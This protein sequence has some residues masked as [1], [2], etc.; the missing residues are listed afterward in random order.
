MAD[1]ASLG[2]GLYLNDGNFK[3]RLMGAYRTAGTQSRRFSGTIQKD[4]K[5]IEAAYKRVGGS[6]KSVAGQ[7]AGITGL[8]LSLG[9]IINASRK[10]G[11]A[12]SDLSAITGITGAQLKKL[13]QTAQEMGRSTGYGA[14]QAAEALKLM[15]SAKPELIQLGDSLSIATQSALTLAQAGGTTLPDATRA[16]ALSLNQFGAGAKEADRYI[17][18]LAAGAKY[19]ASEIADTTEAIKKSGVTAAQAGIGFEQL[20][21]AIQVLAAREVK[22]AEAGTALRNVI[23]LLERSTEKG[24]KPSVVGLSAALENLSKKNYST[25]QAV[26]LFGLENINAATILLES[27]NN[28]DKLTASLTGTQTAHEQASIR[29]NTLNGDLQRLSSTFDGLILKVGD[30]STGTLRTGI[31]SLTD[32]LGFLANNFDTVA[33]IAM[34][35]LLPVLAGKMTKGLQ[36]STAEWWKQRNAVIESA[37]AQK[38]IAQKTLETTAVQLKQNNLAFGHYMQMEKSNKQHGIRV[39]YAK[40]YNQLI[41]EETEQTKLQDQAKK[42]LDA[43]NKTLAFSTRAV[44]T[45]L[46]LANGALSLMGGPLGL[47][48]LAGSAILYFTNKMRGAANQSQELADKIDSVLGRMDNI[49]L[50]EVNSVISEQTKELAELQKEYTKLEKTKITIPEYSYQGTPGLNKELARL[51]QIKKDN[52]LEELKGKI[53]EGNAN[54][55]ALMG[56]Q[57]KILKG[58]KDTSPASEPQ[59]TLW[60]NAADS[61]IT[62]TGP[63]AQNN[64]LYINQYQQ[65]RAEIERTHMGS[66]A[67]INAEEKAAQRQLLDT[68]K[69]SGASLSE[70]HK[71][72]ALNSENYQRQRQVLAEQYSPEKTLLRKEQE[73]NQEL[74]SLYDAR[75]LTESEYYAAKL[76]LQR[77]TESEKIRIIAEAETQPKINPAGDID[78][79]I[80]LQNQL[81]QQRGLYLAHYRLGNID[82]QRYEQLNQAATKQSIDA[83][84]Q[85]ALSLYSGQSQMHKMQIGLIDA[86]KERSTNMMTGWLTGTQTFKDSMLGLFASL[87]QSIIQNLMEMAVQAMITS[88][89]LKSVMGFSGGGGAA[90]G[91][92]NDVFNSG[93]FN[94]LSLNANGGVYASPSLS[95]YSGQVVSQPT[96]FAFAHGAGVMGEAGPEAIMPLKRGRDGKL[97]VSVDTSAQNITPSHTANVYITINN[98]GEANTQADAGWE[99]FA[100]QMGNIA[101]QKS[102]EI[103]NRNLRPGGAI[104]KTVKGT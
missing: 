36:S 96:F 80:Q 15:A 63:S 102:Q 67:R 19:G 88:T 60:A 1:I 70:V 91:S 98:D 7:L 31:Q 42:N 90:A 51:D 18:V 41:R 54:L 68:A 38:E 2:V 17:N 56:E 103:I 66:L 61:D 57:A 79:L 9:T 64:T 34:H 37:K 104:W 22:G 47:A 20:N 28:L 93:A 45:S 73:A 26:K 40:E 21:A 50:K 39:S 59:K 11:Q 87:T 44:T 3:S 94:N 65:L 10:Y 77:E 25:T 76:K 13:D 84:Y 43:A 27:R 82:K 6:I 69:S 8:G 75:L 72:M 33:T 92:T 32:T 83:Q 30:S 52:R 49:R 35:T 89:I 29:M 24:L 86:L 71:L 12:L 16:L 74:K 85:Q 53:K 5:D 78:P 58:E 48:M 99:D 62:G 101:A 55:A 23:L 97:G 46:R 95:A 100:K 14:S 4:A 81:E